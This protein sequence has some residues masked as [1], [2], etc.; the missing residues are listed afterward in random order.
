MQIQDN[1]VRIVTRQLDKRLRNRGS[2]FFTN[3]RD[4]L[5][6]PSN[7][8]FNGCRGLL[9]LREAKVK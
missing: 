9:H 6:G 4:R 7:L 5:W 2:M 8:L 1:V 3:T